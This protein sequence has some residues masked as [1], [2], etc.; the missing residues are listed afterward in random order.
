MSPRREN[1]EKNRTFETN[2]IVSE[3]VAGWDIPL[4]YPMGFLTLPERTNHVI[5]ELFPEKNR[6]LCRV[7]FLNSEK[8]DA[9]HVRL[10]IQR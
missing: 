10:L 6:L 3:K 7:L 1:I 8:V 2:Q 9:K 4:G 5:D